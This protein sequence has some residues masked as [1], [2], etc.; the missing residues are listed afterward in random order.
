MPESPLHTA[1]LNA[2]PQQ[3]RS[4]QIM[5]ALVTWI[6]ERGLKPGDRLPP[7]RDLTAALKVGRSSLREAVSQLSALGVLEARIGSGTYLK[8]RVTPGTHYMP[9][10][11]TADGLAEALLMTLEVRRGIEI[12]ASIAA[13]RRRTA[14]DIVRMEVALN[15]M[16][17]A[18]KTEG[19]SGKA[20]F[21]YHMTIYDAAHN[22]LF[23]QL[24]EQ[25]RDIVERFWEQP[26]DR[27]DFAARSFPFH[28]TLFNAI[29]DGDAEAAA[30]ETRKILDV[31]EEDI[32]NMRP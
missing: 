15:E 1:G 17:S 9:L 6:D 32:R 18:H 12:E 14:D 22:P 28:R 31:V 13:A 25:M 30:A 16:E 20:D 26:F 19:G 3:S 4:R 7:E 23:R 11:V 24:L 2:L 21:A 29:R 27:P 8:R 5:D 10:T